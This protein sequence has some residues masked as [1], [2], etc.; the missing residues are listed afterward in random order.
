MRL[1]YNNEQFSLENNEST[2]HFIFEKIN[3]SIKHKDM[4]FSHLIVDDKEVFENHERYL[5]E[6]LK[7]IEMVQIVNKRTKNMIWETMT[8]I[9]L[10]LDRAIPALINLTDKS[11]KKFTNDTWE[12]INQLA[13]GMQWI[14]Q[15]ITFT[16]KAFQQPANWSELEASFND[17]EASFTKLLDAIKVKDTILISDILSYEVIPAYES[18][19]KNIK[20][21]LDDKEFLK[22]VN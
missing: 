19:N 20:N 4:I 2:I 18:F 22:D 17:S 9:S 6:N 8:S 12:G 5:K 14:T 13:E 16:K 15:F 1:L 11:Y 3:K 10:Y 21:S 7:V